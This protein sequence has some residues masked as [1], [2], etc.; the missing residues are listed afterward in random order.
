MAKQQRGETLDLLRESYGELVKAGSNSLAKAYVFGQV[1]N[2]LHR[3]YT[4]T[5]LG[6]AIGR[7]HTTMRVYA[8]LAKKYPTEKALLNTAEKL[9][10]YDVSRL[11]G[12]PVTTP[13]HYAW[14]CNN[15]GSDDVVKER[16]PGPR[17]PAPEAAAA[18]S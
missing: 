7:S 8:M 5:E 2:A 15:C 3:F 10:T 4:Y 16:V 18:A 13:S 6:D 17:E 9:G 1:V 11:V 14:H 12:S